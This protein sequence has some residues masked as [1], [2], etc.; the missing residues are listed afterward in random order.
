MGPSF[1]M[2]R[3]SSLGL[4][5]LVALASGYRPTAMAQQAAPATQPGLP[6]EEAI[7]RE[8]E[9]LDETPESEATREEAEEMLEP[10]A[11]K[12]W[13]E[14]PYMLGDWGGVRT[15]LEDIGVKFGI[16]YN[17]FYGILTNGGQDLNNAQRNSGSWDVLVWVDFEKMGLIPGGELFVWPKGH[18]SR[19]INDKVGALGEPFDDADG[20][21]VIYI[22]VCRY[23][24]SFFD[25]KLVFQVGYLD[26]Q[27]A[28][29]RN[30]YANSED[31][32]FFN[33]Y[34]D[35]NNA[36][37]PLTIGLGA[38]MF[39]N[40][41][42]WLTLTIGGA[43]GNARLFRTGF[44]TAF[45]DDASFFG[46]FQTEFKIKVPSS[47]GD[48]PGHYRFG[49]LY[50]PRGKDRYDTGVLGRTMEVERGDVG[51]YMSLDQMLLR[52]SPADMQGL[53][54]FFRYGYR[55]GDVNR[56]EHFWS[57]GAQYEG[58]IPKRNKDV[59]GFGMYSV[60][61][62][63]DYREFVNDDFR[64][65]TGYELYYKIQVTP[66]LTFTPDLQYIYQPGGLTS[67]TDAFVIG[68]RARVI[69]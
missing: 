51:F 30:A 67:A 14:Q 16:Y 40:P 58:L 17:H 6:T 28:L 43:D 4:G 7:E 63:E 23:Q 42:E 11:P 3:T 52:E 65:E 12:S 37:I 60:I 10:E 29:D 21:K 34:L 61:A 53:G 46:Y 55:H 8:M 69:F 31:R 35:N 33:T 38:T 57:T 59:L 25:R 66:W 13:F 32:Q 5:L 20:D 26:Q 47:N 22:D 18:F 2:A 1:A 62:S 68:F 49:M 27:V 9:E 45:H 15:E 41:T 64:R 24:Q 44:D 56:I 48:L 50:D 54:W 39:I 19:N 36:I